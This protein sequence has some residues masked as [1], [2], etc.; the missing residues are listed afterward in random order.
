MLKKSTYNIITGETLLKNITQR[1]VPTWWTPIDNKT[2]KHN[3]NGK[4][5]VLAGLDKSGGFIKNGTSFFPIEN[6]E[7]AE[8]CPFTKKDVLSWL[9]KASSFDETFC[10]PF[11]TIEELQPAGSD[12]PF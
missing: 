3:R 6:G 9:P 5:Y 4:Q 2:V 1:P 10:L 11:D 12:L 7:V 8:D